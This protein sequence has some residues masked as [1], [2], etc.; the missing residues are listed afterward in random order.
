[1]LIRYREAQ[2]YTKN[3]FGGIFF[4]IIFNKN[5]KFFYSNEFFSFFENI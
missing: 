3:D 4:D 2:A 1:M 5:E